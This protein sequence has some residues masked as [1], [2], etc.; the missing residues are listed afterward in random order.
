MGAP[1][2]P[3]LRVDGFRR[4]GAIRL[5]EQAL[6]SAT[7]NRAGTVAVRGGRLILE[8]S[9]VESATLDPSDG[10]QVAIDIDI[11]GDIV[12][13]DFSAIAS[14]SAGP[15]PRR[16]GDVRVKAAGSVIIDE[17]SFISATGDV[18]L[19][20][21]DL[22]M[23]GGGVL[24]FRT[25]GG[26][27][28]RTKVTAAE[29]VVLDSRSGPSTI[30]GEG[31]VTV[32]GRNIAVLRGSFIDSDRTGNSGGGDVTVTASESIVVDGFNTSETTISAVSTLGNPLDGGRVTVSARDITVQRGANI[33]SDSTGPGKG[34]DVTVTAARSLVV[35]GRG[36]AGLT[37]IS[38][39]AHTDDAGDVTVAAHD[40]TLRNGASIASETSS[41]RGGHVAVTARDITVRTGGSIVSD[42]FGSGRG[43]NVVVA[44][45][46][47][48]TVD[49]RGGRFAGISAESL[50]TTGPAGSVTVTARDISLT[51]GAVIST[52]TETVGEGGRV[53]V[54]AGQSLVIA[55]RGGTQ[56]SVAAI[57]SDTSGQGAAGE[58]R[59]RAQHLE[60]RQGGQISSTSS[61]AESGMAGRVDIVAG[62]FTAKDGAVTT[63]ALGSDGG[64][65]EIEVTGLLH[66]RDS[67]ISSAVGAG[68]GG[69]GNISIAPRA[70]VLDA[71]TISADAFGGPGGNVRIVAD[72]LLA[73]PDSRITASS[74]L[75]VSGA[76][77]ISTPVSDITSAVAPL[78]ERFTAPTV[79][80]S[81]R[82]S[83]PGRQAK[84]SRF[85]LGGH[86]GVASDPGAWLA[87]LLAEAG[88]VLVSLTA[89]EERPELSG[90]RLVAV[91]PN[92]GFSVGVAPG[93]EECGR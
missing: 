30:S 9:A 27:A 79:L 5:R 73:S 13:L 90:I 45:S 1:N 32:D 10:R 59:A 89:E 56:G 51:R 49:G 14:D 63:S 74:A 34:G 41:G 92:G 3:R 58:V 2:R 86:G 50:G 38:A 33:S 37:R 12:L 52:S 39:S 35:D 6:A 84:T 20:V 93:Q 46:G 44:A 75:G 54:T 19:T 70:V 72:V 66:L 22:T 29:S 60:L 25:A 88:D 40:I 91:A 26:S 48:L 57:R 81:Q 43:G 16:A 18:F 15:R 76:V 31:G 67:R 61:G 47:S 69:G 8:N 4:L 28:G 55:G 65:I 78:P 7:G 68:T 80:V 71:S 64:G 87:S 85:I 36:D 17:I 21:R 42:T 82:C 83:A 53:A 62:M 23:Q 24:A 11:D 77:S